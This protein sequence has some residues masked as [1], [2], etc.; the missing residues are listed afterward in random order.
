[1]LDDLANSEFRRKFEAKDRLQSYL[2]SIPASVIVH[3]NSA[4]I[5]VKTL[6]GQQVGLEGGRLHA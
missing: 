6:V 1:M 4:F 3:P 2:S 5:G